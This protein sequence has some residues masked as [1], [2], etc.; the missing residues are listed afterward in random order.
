MSLTPGHEVPHLVTLNLTKPSEWKGPGWSQTGSTRP[1]T[2]TA[3]ICLDFASAASF[4][5]LPSRPA[6]ILAPART[7]HESVG[8]AM[9][10]QAQ[11]RAAES[12]ATVLWCDGGRGGLSGLASARHSEIVQVGPGSWSMPVGLPYPLDTRR[13]WYMAGGQGAAA[14]AVWA[15]AL[16][17]LLVEGGAEA[18]NVGQ[19]LA[20]VRRVLETLRRRKAP[21]DGNLIDV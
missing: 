8:R 17:G 10:E 5:A 1:V 7:W 20:A 9:W 11:A 6:L 3:S 2:L 4:T 16:V 21:A 19:A 18:V 14:A 13:T 12:G 15:V